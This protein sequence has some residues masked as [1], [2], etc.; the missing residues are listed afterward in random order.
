MVR[1]R[2]YKQQ[3]TCHFKICLQSLRILATNI[4]IYVLHSYKSNF[5][6]SFQVSISLFAF[7]LGSSAIHTTIHKFEMHTGICLLHWSR[8]ISSVFNS[9]CKKYSL[10]EKTR[11][12][13]TT[14]LPKCVYCLGTNSLFF[15]HKNYLFS[16]LLLKCTYAYQDNMVTPLITSENFLPIR[17][18]QN[19]IHVYFDI[20][21]LLTLTMHLLPAKL[22]QYKEL[23]FPGKSPLKPGE[24]A[25]L[26]LH[27]LLWKSSRWKTQSCRCRSTVIKGVHAV[28]TI[29]HS[30]S[31]NHC[32]LLY[33]N[34][35]LPIQSNHWWGHILNF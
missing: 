15:C 14:P 26:H 33:N 13:Q 11:E 21:R 2:I 23:C 9:W 24:I 27:A 17:E 29:P 31:C 22:A 1:C 19:F 32:I 12:V 25:C 8:D 34:N 5:G 28:S 16:K 18:F 35:L 4:Q 6:I 7:L 30:Q 20:T 3:S 10:L